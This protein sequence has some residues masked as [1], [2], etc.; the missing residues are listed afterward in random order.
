MNEVS[1][2]VDRI[3]EGEFI[4]EVLKNPEYYGFKVT[5]PLGYQ[6]CSIRSQTEVEAVEAA[7]RL[8]TYLK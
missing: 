3:N 7:R 6:Y 2:V 4:I 8:I 1:K 5:T